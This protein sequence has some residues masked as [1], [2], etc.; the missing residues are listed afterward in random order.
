MSTVAHIENKGQA[1][2]MIH[3]VYMLDLI[4]YLHS[5]CGA[6]DRLLDAGEQLRHTPKVVL[7]KV[8]RH[9]ALG[10]IRKL[11]CIAAATIVRS[12]TAGA[13]CMAPSNPVSIRSISAMAIKGLYCVQFRQSYFTSIIGL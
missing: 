1:F 11:A 9:C 13:L 3:G 7:E 10:R 12:L 6:V 8:L 2:L 4:S 5:C